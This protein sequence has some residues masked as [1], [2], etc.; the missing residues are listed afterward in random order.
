MQMIPKPKRCGL[1]I[2]F[3]ITAEGSNSSGEIGRSYMGRVMF[4]SLVVTQKESQMISEM[5]L[6][7]SVPNFFSE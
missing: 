7:K 1:G 2:M 4:L 5:T 3:A 6:S